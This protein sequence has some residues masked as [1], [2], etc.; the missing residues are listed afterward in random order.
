MYVL[1]ETVFEDWVTFQYHEDAMPPMKL[2]FFSKTR[3]KTSKKPSRQINICKNSLEK[4]MLKL[5]ILPGP[6]FSLS[7][8]DRLFLSSTI[9]NTDTDIE[10]KPFNCRCNCG[11]KRQI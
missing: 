6:F 4:S 1:S 10:Y 8:I 11:M 9:H 7:M 2:Q 5:N 3:K